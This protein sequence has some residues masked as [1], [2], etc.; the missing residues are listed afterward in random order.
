MGQKLENRLYFSVLD[1]TRDLGLLIADFLHATVTGAEGDGQATSDNPDGHKLKQSSLKAKKALAKRVIKAVQTSLE[2]AVRN[3][4]QLL[5]VPPE[6]EIE[7]L[8]AILDESLSLEVGP[9]MA[10]G[11]HDVPSHPSPDLAGAG[12]TNGLASSVV[13]PKSAESPS[14]TPITNGVIQPKLALRGGGRTRRSTASIEDV[15]ILNGHA[16]PLGKVMVGNGSRVSPKRKQ[17][18]RPL[19]ARDGGVPW[20][21]QNF[22]PEG[23]RIQEE[24]WS[25][26][27]LV[28]AMSEDLSDSTYSAKS[29]LIIRF[30]DISRGIRDQE[31][32]NVL[33]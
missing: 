13:S 26:R 33:W 7:R 12:L 31:H 4:C 23:T 20:Y 10:N 6:A 28:R 8:N 5:R 9:L 19:P 29:A 14:H 1:F 11:D 22:R 27:E 21:M 32:V 3:E 24:Q 30:E 16:Q 15:P 2:E 25:G 17:D 18:E